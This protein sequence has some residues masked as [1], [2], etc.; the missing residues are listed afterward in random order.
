M[1]FTATIE[2]GGKTATGIVVPPE[3]VT[4]LGG[5]KRPPVRVTFSGYT[6]RT[7]VAQRGGR[8]LIPVS[9]EVRQRAGVAAGDR[10]EV[11]LA[12]DTAPRELTV[13]ADLAAALDRE[14]A[15]R[16]F[17]DRLSYS[18]RQWHVL[19]VEGAKTAGT[20]QRRIEKSVGML[21]DGRA[22]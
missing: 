22:R 8:F 16:Q 13:P 4:A 7:T 14:P 12:L 21:R 9:A 2:L 19:Q 18:N 11:E 15:A 1:R 6:Y 5:G 20:R 17:F 3:V 10:V